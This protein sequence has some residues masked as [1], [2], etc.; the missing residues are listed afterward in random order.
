[1]QA[2]RDQVAAARE[3]L[4]TECALMVDAGTVWQEDIDA[5]SQRIQMLNDFDVLCLSDP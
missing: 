3:G 4:G 2:D 5:A 1:M